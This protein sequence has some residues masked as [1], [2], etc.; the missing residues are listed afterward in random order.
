MKWDG[1][2]Q[3]SDGWISEECFVD[4]LL[5]SRSSQMCDEALGLSS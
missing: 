3:R 2:A 5:F 1:D 4:F